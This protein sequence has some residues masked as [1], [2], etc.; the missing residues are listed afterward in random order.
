VHAWLQT[1]PA[2]EIECD[3][4]PEWFVN[5]NTPEELVACAASLEDDI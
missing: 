5:L 1:L 3:D 4:H 2:A